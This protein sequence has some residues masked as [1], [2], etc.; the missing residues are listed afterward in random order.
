MRQAARQCDTRPACLSLARVVPRN[1]TLS[2]RF[3]DHERHA[4]C[5]PR[6][7][8]VR[9]PLAC[10][11]SES[12]RKISGSAAS[13]VARAGASLF[14]SLEKPSV[15]ANPT[16]PNAAPALALT[17]AAR[18][19]RAYRRVRA[20]QA[21]NRIEQTPW[22]PG[23][24]SG[25]ARSGFRSNSRRNRG[26]REPRGQTPGPVRSGHGRTFPLHAAVFSGACGRFVRLW[27]TALGPGSLWKTAGRRRGRHRARG[28]AT[29]WIEA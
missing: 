20:G 9:G 13:L 21:P 11:E 3:G 8:P 6:P 23:C 27:F 29:A 16:P 19:V 28:P 4:R 26:G 22:P 7:A 12:E 1:G 15:R 18:Q 10:P 24:G 17:Y 5:G 2:P 14:H 25:G